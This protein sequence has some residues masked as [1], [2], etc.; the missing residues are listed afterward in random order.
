MNPKSPTVKRRKDLRRA[1]GYVALNVMLPPEVVA[2][3][4]VIKQDERRAS[5]EKPRR[6]STLSAVCTAIVREAIRINESADK[7]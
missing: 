7:R 5:P 2:A 3:L 4:E 1:R 6:G